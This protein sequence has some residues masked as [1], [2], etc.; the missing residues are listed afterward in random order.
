MY[1]SSLIHELTVVY[2]AMPIFCPKSPK[3]G[4]SNHTDSSG[5]S[6]SLLIRQGL[7][8]VES[9]KKHSRLRKRQ[10]CLRLTSGTLSTYYSVWPVEGHLYEIPVSKSGTIWS[11][12]STTGLWRKTGLCRKRSRMT[13]YWKSHHLSLGYKNHGHKQ[14]RACS[15]DHGSLKPAAPSI[16]SDCVH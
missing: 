4:Q 5:I 15:K 7:D 9:E 6:S 13:K 2:L 3:H 8:T 16:C 10:P 11:Q 1:L 12:M 14:Q